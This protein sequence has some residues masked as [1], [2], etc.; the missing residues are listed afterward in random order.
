MIAHILLAALLPT[1]A[2]TT[3]SGATVEAEIA[4]TPQSRERGLMDRVTL[5]EDAGMLFVFPEDGI[6]SFWMKNTRIPL[7]I[8]W[9]DSTH[10]A[11]FISRDTPPCPVM[12]L[13]CPTYGPDIPA[14][15]VLELGAGRGAEL[16]IREGVQLGFELPDDLEISRHR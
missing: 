11:L 4:A 15:Y 10:K 7:D 8:I 3:P 5:D 6:Y 12:R 2:V 14:R 16:G 9:L 1:V 13:Q